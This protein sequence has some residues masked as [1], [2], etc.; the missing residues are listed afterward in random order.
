MIR[1]PGHIKAGEVSN[2]MFSGLDWFPTLL[3]AAGDT[4]DEGS[5][6]Q[7]LPRIGGKT[8]KVHL[9]GYNQLAY[10]T[11]KSPTSARDEFYYFDDDGDLV[12]M[13]CRNNWKA[14]FCEQRAAG[15]FDVWANPFTCL[16]LPKIF[17]LRMDPYE[18]ADIVPTST[19]TGSDRTP[20]WRRGATKAAAFLETFVDIRRASA[21]ASFSVDQVRKRRRWR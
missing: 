11:G 6:A 20:T 17:N 18:R 12:A 16:R 21:P 14:V 2:E 1:W 4:D 5:P 7:G 8:F 15:R 3:A 19:T 13:R 10:L 9:D